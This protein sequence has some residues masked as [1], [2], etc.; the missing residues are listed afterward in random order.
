MWRAP[1]RFVAPAHGF[2]SDKKD[3][4]EPWQLTVVFHCTFDEF[5]VGRTVPFSTLNRPRFDICCSARAPREVAGSDGFVL[6]VFV[7]HI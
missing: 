6:F 2:V 4:R 3:V 5:H 1:P 7:L